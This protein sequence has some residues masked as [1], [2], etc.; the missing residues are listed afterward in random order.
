MPRLVVSYLLT[1]AANDCRAKERHGVTASWP[2]HVRHG[3]LVVVRD[4]PTGVLGQHDGTAA[5]IRCHA[6]VSCA[7]VEVDVKRAAIAERVPGADVHER[8]VCGRAARRERG[9]RQGRR[10][11]ER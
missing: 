4:T 8:R 5:P 10:A 7:R 11:H 2:A 9:V 3:V 6:G 1:I